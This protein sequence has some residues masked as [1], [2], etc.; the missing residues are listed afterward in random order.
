M[1]AFII[2]CF[3]IFED[4]AS[5]Q[6]RL[7]QLAR[8]IVL[9]QYKDDLQPLMADLP[10]QTDYYTVVAQNVEILLKQ[11]FFM[12]GGMDENVSFCLSLHVI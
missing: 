9:L 12:C 6:G 1:V 7:K 2:V 10:N 8:D 3:Q 5:Y 4:G 11:G